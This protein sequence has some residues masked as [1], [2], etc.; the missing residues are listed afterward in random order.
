VVVAIPI[1]VSDSVESQVLAGMGFTN[2]ELPL[3]IDAV[4]SWTRDAQTIDLEGDISASLSTGRSYLYQGSMPVPPCWET[5]TWIVMA[6]PMKATSK[7]LS[8]LHVVLQRHTRQPNSPLGGVGLRAETPFER[9]QEAAGGGQECREIWVNSIEPLAVGHELPTCEQLKNDGTWQRS[10]RC[11]D[12]VDPCW[13][14]YW[15]AVDVDTDLAVG[16]TADSPQ[17]KTSDILHWESA[18]GVN[19]RRSTYSFDIDMP[20]TSAGTPGHFG[21]IS[22]N[23]HIYFAERVSVKA[24]SQHTVNGERYAGEL[25]I[26]HLMYGDDFGV[27]LPGFTDNYHMVAVSI[28][29]QLGRQKSAFIDSL[30]LSTLPDLSDGEQHYVERTLDLARD[31]KPSIDGPW[32]WYSSA[33]THPNLTECEQHN[34]KNT[35]PVRWMVFTTPLPVDIEQLNQITQAPEVSGIDSSQDVRPIPEGKLWRQN[36]PA[37]AVETDETD[38]RN[39]E[40]GSWKYGDQFDTQ[41]PPWGYGNVRCWKLAFDICEAGTR[42][43]PINIPIDNV[44]DHADKDVF[45]NRVSYHPVSGLRV[46]NTGHNLQVSDQKLGYVKLMGDNGFPQFYEVA[47]FHVHMPAEHLIGG[48]QYACEIHVVHF[49]QLALRNL[50]KNDLLVTAFFFDKDLNEENPFLKQIFIRNATVDEGSNLDAEGGHVTIHT[51]VDLMQVFGPVLEGNFYRYDGSLTT[52]PCSESVKWFV[53]ETALP[54]SIQQ[55]LGFK[56]FYPN[57]GNNRP[58]QAI[59]GRAIHKNSFQEGTLKHFDFYLSRDAGRDRDYKSEGMILLPVFGSVVL[60]VFV[61]CFTFNRDVRREKHT[62]AG[63]LMPAAEQQS[64]AGVSTFGKAE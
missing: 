52:P 27:N 63:G 61:M 64:D 40:M 22:L 47:Q 16:P 37:Y 54:M 53:F 39:T 46:A 25:T 55:W 59:N 45:L 7:Q 28:P 1:T 5:V 29:L 62:S 2:E 15:S 56:E 35:Y 41:A 30:S 43:S 58:F 49:R 11:W 23:G 44:T 36:L 31:L 48:K 60:T 20:L 57:P 6:T 38:C 33:S 12:F 13:G 50:D 18:S 4:S 17:V 9:E 26:Q 3:G 51:P 32:Y 42:Q 10:A 8:N 34:S 19:V 24:V 21:S 14:K